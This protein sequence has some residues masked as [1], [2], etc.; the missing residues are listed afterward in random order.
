VEEDL[1]LIRNAI[2]DV[3][4]EASR[5]GGGATSSRWARPGER[6]F[7]R[8]WVPR[9]QTIRHMDPVRGGRFINP[10]DVARRRRVLFLGQ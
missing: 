5:T 6:V 10:A 4:R 9:H 7:S 2:P 3:D 1:D 8:A